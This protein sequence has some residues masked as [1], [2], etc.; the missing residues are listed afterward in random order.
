MRVRY[1]AS[2]TAKRVLAEAGTTGWPSR[3]AKQ[4]DGAQAIPGAL[5]RLPLWHI[6]DHVE[7]FITDWSPFPAACAIAVHPDHYLGSACEHRPNSFT[8]KYARHPLTGDLIP[9]WT[10]GWVRPE[11]GT[12]TVIVNPAHSSVDLDFAKELGLPIRFGLAPTPPT[13][14]PASWPEPPVIDT[15]VAVRTGV[16][17]G[18]DAA[19]ARRTYL[20]LLADAGHASQYADRVLA[21]LS[22]GDASH[23]GWSHISHA[24]DEQ[25]LR[26]DDPAAA[27]L[28]GPLRPHAV[29]VVGNAV[30]AEVLALRAL[31]IDVHGIDIDQPSVHLVAATGS[32]PKI[33]DARVRDL[34]LIGFAGAEEVLSIKAPNV[35][36]AERFVGNHGRLDP[37]AATDL[38]TNTPKRAAALLS[39]VESGRLANAFSELYKLQRDLLK[40]PES[41]SAADRF[42]YFAVAHVLA[43]A[44]PPAAYPLGETLELLASRQ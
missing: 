2:T 20:S 39:H 17:D 22:I 37:P 32:V 8:G 40:T 44:D 1:A 23:E 26:I 15:G 36:Q 14:D 9:I 11:F 18:A 31:H 25:V 42:A 24:L 30:I 4:L 10:A 33:D 12:G 29:I 35:E 27:V 16:A 34:A 19:D 7:A 43:D 5:F 6:D 38:S 41:V 13:T 3:V 21:T 28:D